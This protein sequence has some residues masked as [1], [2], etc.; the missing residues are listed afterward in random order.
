MKKLFLISVFCALTLFSAIAQEGMWMLTQLTQL[1]LAKKGLMIP[2]E[3]LYNPGKPCIANAVLQLGGG[4]ASFVSSEGLVVTNHHVAYT[5][6]QTGF[7]C[8]E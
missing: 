8:R 4:S 6:L 3:Q 7:K 5:A 1:D 2:V